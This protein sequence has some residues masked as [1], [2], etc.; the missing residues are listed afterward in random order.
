MY[1]LAFLVLTGVLIRVIININ[2]GITPQWTPTI[3]QDS[4]CI[5]EFLTRY[6][7]PFDAINTANC[8]TLRCID[9]KVEPSFYENTSTCLMSYQ[10]DRLKSSIFVAPLSLAL[11]KSGLQL[12]IY[13]FS[14]KD[15]ALGII[16][17]YI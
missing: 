17:I 6:N 3:R 10:I 15:L 2:T 9:V 8:V 12:D 1:R 7:E 4:T 16:W 5:V 11:S 14:K 13:I